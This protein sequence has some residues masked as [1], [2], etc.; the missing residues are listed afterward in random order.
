MDSD[1][2]PGPRIVGRGGRGTGGWVWVAPGIGQPLPEDRSDKP[3]HRQH[4]SATNENGSDS[5]VLFEEATAPPSEG[6]PSS[7][8]PEETPADHGVRVNV[9][10]PLEI[11]SWVDPPTR[12]KV[13]EALCF[14]ALHRKRPMTMEELQIALSSDGDDAPETSAKS[15]RTY[16]SELRRSLGAEHVPSA[17]GSGYRLADSVSTDWDV[18]RS[19][20]ALRP[21]EFDDQVQALIDALNLV[22]GRPFAGTDY[23]WVNSELLVSEMEV[24]ISDAAR[25]L[26]KIAMASKRNLEGI[27]YFAGRRA[28]LACPYDIGLWEMAM[29]AAA[30]FDHDELVR[31]WREAQATLGEDPTALRDLAERLGLD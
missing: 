28:A 9:M 6:E 8:L 4:D 23:A 10:G 5:A 18:F 17:R 30:A 31:T 14:L 20:V 29:E 21:T 24:A 2:Y 25:R 7:P 1:D 3:S 22:R 26:G 16:M 11:E 15:V 12:H 27:A 19:L 13:T